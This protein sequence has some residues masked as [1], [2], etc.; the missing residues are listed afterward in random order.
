ML[1]LPLAARASEVLLVEET[2]SGP[3]RVRRRFALG[4]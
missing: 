4:A 3:L 2:G 1:R